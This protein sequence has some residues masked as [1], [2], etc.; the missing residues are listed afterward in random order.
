[1]LFG[2]FDH[3]DRGS[4]PIQEYYENRLRVIEHYDRAGLYA[5]HVAEHHGT[6]LGMSPSPSVFLSAVAQRTKRLR[7]GPMV[8]CLPLYH[9]VRLLEEISMLDQMSGGRFELGVGRGI[10]P[11]EAAFYGVSGDDAQAKY[12]EGFDFIRNGLAAETF[13]FQGKHYSVRDF[14]R[15]ITCFQKPHPPLW[16]GV[17]RPDSAKWTGE[18]GINVICN[19]PA[20]VVRDVCAQYRR[21]YAKAG[22]SPRH[23]PLLGM[24][25]HIV[26]GETKQ[27]ALQA[28]RRAYLHWREDFMNLW[29]RYNKTPS[30]VSF[31]LTF[32]ELAEEGLGCAGSVSDVRDYVWREI[33]TSG[34]NYFVSRF[35]FGD[36]SVEEITTSVDLFTREVCP[37]VQE[38]A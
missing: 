30:T 20:T 7:F 24:N 26:V 16:Y 38:A 17:A 6:P 13:T 8:Y 10:S 19:Q 21:S 32:D 12:Q 18:Q 34:V 23:A 9:P 3:V 36:L 35:A 29:T 15:V 1:M 28:A 33:E 2:V 5:Y 11:I 31:P 37:A 25:R 4:V 22:H 27:D 14:P